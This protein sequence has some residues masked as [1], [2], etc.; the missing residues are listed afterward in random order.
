MK[1]AAGKDNVMAIGDQL[2]LGRGVGRLGKE[3]APRGYV[4][5]SIFICFCR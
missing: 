1:T 3:N 5:Y 2:Q 4:F